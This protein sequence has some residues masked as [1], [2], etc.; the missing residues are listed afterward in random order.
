MNLILPDNWACIYLDHSPPH[1]LSHILFFILEIF[2]GPWKA[3]RELIY[4]V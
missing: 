3:S 1:I 4:L 2:L